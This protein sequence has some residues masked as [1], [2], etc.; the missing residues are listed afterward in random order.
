MINLLSSFLSILQ[1]I[2]SVLIALLVFM[3]MITVHEFG[4][5]LAGRILK[6]QINEFAVGMGP[7][8]LSKKGKDGTTYSLRAL[9]F[10]GFCAFEGENKEGEESN[11]RAFNNQKPWKRIIV[12]ISGALFNFIS[13]ILICAIVFS[14]YGET[15]IKV[16]LEF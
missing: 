16:N 8:L 1:S 10:G 11:P 4:H 2:G 12:L 15:A 3:F 14:C 9:P 5:F 7:K 6:F 13:A